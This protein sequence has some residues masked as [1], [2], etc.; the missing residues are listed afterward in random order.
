MFPITDSRVRL[1]AGIGAMAG[2]LAAS[3]ALAGDPSAA[4]A[5]PIGLGEMNPPPR[6]AAPGQTPPA[7]DSGDGGRRAPAGEVKASRFGFD[8]EDATAALQ[9]AID[10]GADNC[11]D[12]TSDAP[13]SALATTPSGARLLMPVGKLYFRVPQGVKQFSVGV[14]GEVDY[15]LIDGS[16]KCVQK[17]RCDGSLV[18]LNGQREDASAGET[19][20]VKLFRPQWLVAIRMYWPLAPL[21]STNAASLFD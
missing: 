17:G 9:A 21:V 19:W 13:G 2:A 10:S 3:W 12:I 1:V 14:A 4:A 8:S 20:A 7:N 15:E 16:G 18:F 11:L 6:P 5:P